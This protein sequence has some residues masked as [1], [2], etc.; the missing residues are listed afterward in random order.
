MMKK[1]SRLSKMVDSS[2]R[3]TVAKAPTTYG[4]TV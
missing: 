3:R 4:G 1:I 2:G